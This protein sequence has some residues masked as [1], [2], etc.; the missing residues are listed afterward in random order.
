MTWQD[1]AI[2]LR[3]EGVSIRETSRKLDVPYSTLWDFL[4]EK[5]SQKHTSFR[6]K[7]DIVNI[8]T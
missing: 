5:S 2:S 4:K 7:Q 6:S 1:E 3:K 8:N